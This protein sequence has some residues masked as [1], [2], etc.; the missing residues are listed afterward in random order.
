MP[1]TLQRTFGI[2]A[3]AHPPQMFRE[4]ANQSYQFGDFV[5]LVANLVVAAVASGSTLDSTGHGLLGQ[6]G[7][8]ARNAANPSVDSNGNPIQDVPVVIPDDRVFYLLPCWSATLA[9]TQNQNVPIGTTATLKN[10]GGIYALNL[11]VTANPILEVVQ[12][13]PGISP[14]DTYCWVYCKILAAGR[15]L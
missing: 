8:A 7:R 6:C 5:S 11:D 2:H 13:L 3:D 15:N 10:V 9:N 4:G 12:K 14:T 1:A